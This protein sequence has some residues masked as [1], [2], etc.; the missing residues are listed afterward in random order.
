MR[1][2]GS[3]VRYPSLFEAHIPLIKGKLDSFMRVSIIDANIPLLIGLN[4]MDKLGFV[5]DCKNNTITTKRTRETFKLDKDDKHLTLEI[6]P[7]TL[8]NEEEVLFNEED[9]PKEKMKKIKKIHHI[10]GHPKSET[11][12]NFYCDS[13]E[14]DPITM[15]M[16]EEVS[17]NCKICSYKYKRT[18]PRPK[19]CLPLSRNFNQCVS[20]DLKGPINKKYIL[21]CVDTFSR[22]TRGIIIKDKNPNTIVK[23]LIDC[24]ILG[25]G[26]GPG[27]PGKFIFDGGREFNNPQVID[28]AE[29]F[30]LPMHNVTAAYAPYSNGI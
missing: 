4:D 30:G 1:K 15:N 29:K 13:P 5:I 9:S 24:W 16:V 8:Q 25:R 11:L 12:K 14:N 27:M 7:M 20:I 17:N 19:T 10:M 28:L 3:N 18:P 26:I 2:R 6:V 23:G 22:L 21:Y